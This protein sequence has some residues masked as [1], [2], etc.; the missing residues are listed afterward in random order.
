MQV[1]CSSAKWHTP[2]TA[3]GQTNIGDRKRVLI[4]GPQNHERG[5]AGKG[6]RVMPKNERFWAKLF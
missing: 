4:M 5:M 1:V 3:M 6:G 2:D